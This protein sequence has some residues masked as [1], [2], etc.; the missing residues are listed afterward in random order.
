[1]LKLKEVIRILD[2]VNL[3]HVIL[4]NKRDLEREINLGTGCGS[5][6]LSLKSKSV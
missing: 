3:L 1:M 6:M 2:T 4:M 5:N